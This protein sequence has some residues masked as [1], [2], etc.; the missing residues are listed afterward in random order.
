MFENL[1]RK[2]KWKTRNTNIGYV[3]CRN[4]KIVKVE[5]FGCCNEDRRNV[6]DKRYARFVC[7]EVRV[8]DI[9]H[10]GRNK[11]YKNAT[12]INWTGY[13]R[14]TIK[15]TLGALVKAPAFDSSI[16][17]G[18]HYYLTEEAAIGSN[19]PFNDTHIKEGDK[20]FIYNI[21]GKKILIRRRKL[22]FNC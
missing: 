13:G 7:S 9:Y 14:E 5:L 1:R 4:N 8:L 6:V 16:D 17:S 22:N 21:N 10:P 20:T 12:L 11:K 15:F 19:G 2:L 18:I 3:K